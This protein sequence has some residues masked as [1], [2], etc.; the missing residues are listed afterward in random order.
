MR[1][2]IIEDEPPVAEEIED[3]IRS[4]LRD[5]IDSLKVFYTFEEASGF[6]K[7]HVIDL[8]FLDLN[9][10]GSSGFDIL[11]Q[12]VSNNFHTIIIS[13]YTE[14]AIEAFSYGVLDFVPKPVDKDRL[15]IALD[16]YLG[17]VENDNLR[18]KYLVVKKGQ[19]HKIIST[20]NIL[21]F[22]AEGYL[23]DIFLKDGRQEIIEKPLNQ[24]EQI[25]PI[26][27]VRVHRSYIVDLNE[28]SF[29]KHKGGSVYEI[30]LKTKTVIPMSYS[31][32]KVLKKLLEKDSIY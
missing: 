20:C 22:K 31:K 25:L 14:Q 28:I 29:Y 1:I 3:L 4:I 23:V 30:H 8:C 16:R 24:L 17:N 32:Y 26:Y 2:L 11:K 13:A 21:F 27:F 9:L 10:S 5:K 15:R 12:T 18:A 6:L 7:H 19:M